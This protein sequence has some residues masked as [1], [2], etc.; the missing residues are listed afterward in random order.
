MRFQ[1]PANIS[2]ELSRELERACVAGGPDNMP[3]PTEAEVED[4]ILVLRREVEES[5]CIIAPWDIDGA[6]QVMTSSGTLIER[7]A[8]YRF[9]LELARGKVNQLR[10]QSAD[11]QM[12]GLVVPEDLAENIKKVGLA[13][14]KAVTAE[15]EDIDAKSLGV[16]GE[17]Y[18]GAETLVQQY[19]E[20][21]FQARHQRQPRLETLL[22]CRVTGA[23]LPHL[24]NDVVL[25]SFNAVCLR[26]AWPEVEPEEGKFA[27]EPYDKII[28]W[29]K[30][31][32][33]QVLAG[34]LVDFSSSLPSWLD[35][36]D[37][38]LLQLATR[39]GN[40]VR[41]TI[42]RYHES[43]RS[44]QLAHS[45][46]RS[47]ELALSEDELLWIAVQ[48]AEAARQVDTN[49]SL[50]IGLVQP[51]GE[52]M[53]EED[54]LHSPFIFADTLIRAG[55]NLSALDIEL[56]MGLA[57]RGSY[58]RDLLDTSRLIDMYTLLGVPLRI[59]LGYPSGSGPDD[60]SEEGEAELGRSGKTFD[61]DAQAEWASRFGALA[62]CKPAIRSVLW[63]HLT[64]AEPHIFPHAGLFDAKNE[65][66]P[67]LQK[68]RELRENHLR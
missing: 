13:F 51:W 6:G 5:G 33:L 41:A 18:Q 47:M 21:M 4:G 3:W 11:W 29:A 53:T 20:Q 24:K 45:A 61:A 1:L 39:M 43:I 30:E 52:Y 59:T 35:P 42:G 65:P 8:P 66:K 54:C 60:K 48:L 64:D 19:I 17:A 16:L 37:T 44:W 7:E 38:D 31:H 12:G 46:N 49:L 25:Q 2:S 56:V 50:A 28:E 26:F 68:L 9:L 40:F 10:C 23:D 15:P 58:Y 34:P 36:Q 55:L 67:V 22:G 57:P 62:L 32:G 14:A 27:W 63:T